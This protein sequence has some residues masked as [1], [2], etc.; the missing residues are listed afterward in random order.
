MT[1]GKGLCRPALSI[2]SFIQ[3][4]L[5]LFH[6]SMGVC[7]WCRLWPGSWCLS[8]HLNHSILERSLQE[9]TV[10]SCFAVYEALSCRA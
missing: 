7:A 10:V 5:L 2:S 3:H 8:P 1:A 6:N 9:L 4:L